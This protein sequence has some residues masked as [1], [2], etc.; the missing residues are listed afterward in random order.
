MRENVIA[1]LND[2]RSGILITSKLPYEFE[3]PLTLQNIA[4]EIKRSM[5]NCRIPELSY[6][7]YTFRDSNPKQFKCN[8]LRRTV[9]GECYKNSVL[10]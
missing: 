10:F 3:H 9:W 5:F 1:L 4:V 6:E 8:E 2:S 7:D